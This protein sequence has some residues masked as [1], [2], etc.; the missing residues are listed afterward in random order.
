MRTAFFLQLGLASLVFSVTTV[1]LLSSNTMAASTDSQIASL[2]R[3]AGFQGGFIVRIGDPTDLKPHTW[4]H[5]AQSSV[6]LLDHNSTRVTAFRL[7][8]LQATGYGKITAD[9]F[10]GQHIPVIDRLVNLLVVHNGYQISDKEMQRVLA[11]EGTA[12]KQVNG[13]WVSF[14]KERP[15]SIDD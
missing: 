9:T 3:Q 6:L 12:W 11:P 1:S 4:P 13:E 8:A 14:R 2:V 15:K 5:I 10:D 7:A